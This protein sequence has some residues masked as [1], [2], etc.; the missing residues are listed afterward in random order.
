MSHMKLALVILAALIA[1]AIPH[2]PS[3]ICSHAGSFLTSQ[4]HAAFNHTWS[5]GMPY[6]AGRPNLRAM[7]IW[8][9][10]LATCYQRV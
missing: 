4:A 5:R 8:A 9:R 1:I 10:L 7:R 6:P 2:I 3:D